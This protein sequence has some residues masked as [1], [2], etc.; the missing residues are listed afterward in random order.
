MNRR[1]VSHSWGL[2][3]WEMLPL[4]GAGSVMHR[5]VF[6][7]LPQVFYENFSKILTD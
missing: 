3:T 7:K 2:G 4:A 5:E 1:K 6:F